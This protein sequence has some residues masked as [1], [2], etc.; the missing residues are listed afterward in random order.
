DIEGVTFSAGSS[1]TAAS[2]ILSCAPNSGSQSCIAYGQNLNVIANGDVAIANFTLGPSVSSTIIRVADALGA[3]VPDS[4][5]ILASGS[6][7][8]LLQQNIPVMAVAC[9]PSTLAPAGACGLQ[10]DIQRAY[11][12]C[13]SSRDR[14]GQ[15]RPDCPGYSNGSC[16]SP[17]GSVHGD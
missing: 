5:T 2:K 13:N 3:S 12:S 14:L 11:S 4:A 16:G 17:I 15:Y 1:L 10:R 9:N 8:T 6:T 7:V